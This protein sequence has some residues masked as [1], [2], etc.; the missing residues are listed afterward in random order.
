MH[1]F[2]DRLAEDVTSCGHARRGAASDSM[3]ADGCT[4]V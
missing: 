1:F 3:S 2:Q 4:P